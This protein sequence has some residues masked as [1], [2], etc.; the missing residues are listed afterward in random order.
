MQETDKP[1]KACKN[2]RETP[3]RKGSV[4]LWTAGLLAVFVVLVNV[5]LL[6]RRNIEYFWYQPLHNAYSLAVALY[7]I[8]RFAICLMYRSPKLTGHEPTVTIAICA[9][10]EEGVIGETIRRS[11][12]V[13][14]PRDKLE[15]IVVNDGS[16]DGTAAEIQAAKQELPRLAAIHFG[17]NRGKRAAMVEAARRAQGD[18]LVYVDSDS[19]LRHDTI[20]RIV[21]PFSDPEV[22]A[23]AGHTDVENA[24][25]N[26]LTR[27]QAVR[28]YVAFRVIKAAESVFSC[29]TCCPGCFSAYKRKYVLE[30]LDEW[31]KQKFLH[32]RVTFGD[33]RSLTNFMLRRHR[34]LYN[35]EAKATTIVP[36]TLRKFL[37]QQLRWKK[38]WARESLIASGFMWK[39]PPLMALSFYLAFLFPVAAPLVVARAMVVAPLVW[40]TPGSFFLY[41]VT[42]MSLLFS[43]YYLLAQRNRLW[44]YGVL[45][46]LFYMSVLI[47]QTPYAL[48]T[49]RHNHWGTR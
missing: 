41:G 12:S 45:F 27:M 36:E 33:D 43:F 46:A 10:N 26:V 21:Q 22:G 34:V 20:R 47:W 16:T 42:C 39:K 32:S 9:K 49:I 37:R 13:N 11:F 18:V 31:E 7:I 4:F 30:V 23:V 29:V 1:P 24:D 19:F 25:V 14:Y 44:I 3:S 8:S 48:L 35:S 15:V 2:L 38:S 5:V 17:E 28:Y 6:K 40:G